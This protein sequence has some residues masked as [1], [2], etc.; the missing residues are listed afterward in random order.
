VLWLGGGIG[1]K[2]SE[3]ERS[4]EHFESKTQGRSVR[5]FLIDKDWGDVII[6]AYYKPFGGDIP[7]GAQSASFL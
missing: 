1:P 4:D 2:T 3:M 7:K 6:F 5:S